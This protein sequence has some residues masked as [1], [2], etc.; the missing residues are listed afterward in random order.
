[1][2]SDFYME[3]DGFIQ[4]FRFNR[5]TD[6]AVMEWATALDDHMASIP[7]KEPFYIMLDVT[8]E[9]V[10]FTSMARQESKRIFTKYQTHVG[11][12]AMVFEWR[13]SPYFAR[14]FFASIGKL[15]FKLNYFTQYDLALDWLRTQHNA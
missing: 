1:M 5:S 15:S 3:T 13:T 2:A 4:I 14:L 7:R 9:G 11:F 8:G 12:L 6:A 10:E